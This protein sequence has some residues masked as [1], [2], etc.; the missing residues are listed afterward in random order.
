MCSSFLL[1]NRGSPQSLDHEYVYTSAGGPLKNCN[2]HCG[3]LGCES[4]P[5]IEAFVCQEEER[6]QLEVCSSC[7]ENHKT[8]AL[9]TAALL[10]YMERLQ[11]LKLVII[12]KCYLLFLMLL[13][14]YFVKTVQ[15]SSSLVNFKYRQDTHLHRNKPLCLQTSVKLFSFFF[16]LIYNL[17]LQCHLHG[18]Y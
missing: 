6:E 3:Y 12:Y 14:G 1:Y 18:L 9:Q 15:K 8:S 10:H 16:F 5:Q 17:P 13:T 2:N 7:G 11:K 4:K